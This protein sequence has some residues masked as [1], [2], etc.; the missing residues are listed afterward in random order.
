MIIESWKPIGEDALTFVQL[1]IITMEEM[2]SMDERANELVKL[3]AQECG[4]MED[5][6]AMLK[7]LFS[8][9]IEEML[10]AEME[11]HL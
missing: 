9:T 3:L 5:V 11:E 10:E 6:H 7:N 1:V 2:L 4:S 8:G